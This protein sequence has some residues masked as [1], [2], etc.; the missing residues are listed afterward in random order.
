[1]LMKYDIVNGSFFEGILMLN[2]A[3]D[4]SRYSD[5]ALLG[6]PDGFFEL[7]VGCSTTSGGMGVGVDVMVGDD[8]IVEV[9]VAV[10]V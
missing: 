7:G 3:P 9:N 10:A 4:V 6:K 5:L 1:M 2:P 8:V